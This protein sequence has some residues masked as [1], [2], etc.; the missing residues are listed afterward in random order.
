MN[1][2]GNRLLVRQTRTGHE[3]VVAV[4]E[5]LEMAAEDIAAEAAK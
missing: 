3:Q 5:Q 2:A 4:L 1:V